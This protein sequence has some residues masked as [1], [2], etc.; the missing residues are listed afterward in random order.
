MYICLLLQF[1]LKVTL[2]LLTYCES[3]HV[4][5]H[6]VFILLYY[7]PNV[8]ILVVIESNPPT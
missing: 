4:V 8:I 7:I 5:A 1:G 6:I 3:Y 2:L